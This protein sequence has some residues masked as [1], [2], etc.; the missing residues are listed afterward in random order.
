ML[1]V[2]FVSSGNS[3]NGISPIV[4]NQGESLREAG[5]DVEYYPVQGKGISGYLKAASAIK[6]YLRDNPVDIIHAHYTLSGWTAVLSRPKQPVVLSLMGTDAYGDYIGVN[7]IKRA[8]WY[9]IFLTYIIQP[10]VQAV[11]C[12]SKHIQSFVYLKKKSRVIPN[13]ILL[14]RI[15]SEKK[16]SKAELGLEPGKR[17]ILFLGNTESRRKNYSLAKEA[18]ALLNR[19]DVVL[20][21]PYPISHD[22]VIRYMHSVDALVAPS[23]M[24]GSPNVVKEAMACNC[25]VVATDVGDISWLFGNEPGH[26]L[27]GFDPENVAHKLNLAL[28]FADKHGRT[29]GRERILELGLDSESVAKRIVEVY[30]EV[31]RRA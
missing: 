11:I 9:L 4:K 31:A 7:K 24:E 28:E 1:K 6:K 17:H 10:F 3:K 15:L 22:Q 19:D 5:V 18:A 20:V 12:K 2:L 29:S 14:D 25:P 30:E 27:C 16:D 23:L 13:G 21:A 26:F 8:S